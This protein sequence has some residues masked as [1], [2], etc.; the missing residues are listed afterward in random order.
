MQGIHWAE[1]NCP[2]AFFFFFSEIYSF[3]INCDREII[4]VSYESSR[5]RKYIK[6]NGN[7]PSLFVFLKTLVS[8]LYAIG[9]WF[10][11]HMKALDAGNTLSWT[12]LPHRLLF[13]WNLYFRFVHSVLGLWT[14]NTYLTSLPCLPSTPLHCLTSAMW[15]Q[16]C[17]HN[18]W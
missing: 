16:L 1:R 5:C 13:F 6:Q 14:V 11:H 17:Q 4:L 15:I 8:L 9:K 12:K 3:V 7:Y 18:K 2:I 10:Y